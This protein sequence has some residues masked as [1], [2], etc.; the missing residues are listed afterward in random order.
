[1]TETHRTSMKRKQCISL[2]QTLQL[3]RKQ[4]K[5]SNKTNNEKT[6]VINANAMRLIETTMKI[7]KKHENPSKQDTM[8]II[9]NN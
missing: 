2:T 1:M 6:I 9:Q 4:T 8:K 3:N 7:T 5:N